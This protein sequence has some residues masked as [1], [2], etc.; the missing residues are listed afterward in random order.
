[1][2]PNEYDQG[3]LVSFLVARYP[4]GCVHVP[5]PP[6]ENVVHVTM[7]EKSKKLRNVSLTKRVAVVG[8]LRSIG[9]V[10]ASYELEG[11]SVKEAD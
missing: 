6:P 8:T 7:S 4:G 10:D 5:L 2:I 1:I 3:E 11:E 9:R